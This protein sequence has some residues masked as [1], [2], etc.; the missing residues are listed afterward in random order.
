[1][2]P[3]LEQAL[4]VDVALSERQLARHYGLSLEV[5]RRAGLNIQTVNVAPTARMKVT[6][7]VNFVT[8]ETLEIPA[9]EFRHL[10]GI[11][12]MRHQLGAGLEDWTLVHH[13]D[14]TSPDAIWRRGLETWAVEFDA[15]SYSQKT[16][17]EKVRSFR[18]GFDGQCWAVASEARARFLGGVLLEKPMVVRGF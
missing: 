13:T 9:F 1:V 5:C 3:H 10:A 17:L 15:G 12:E 4:T 14:H 8:L 7:A 16:I 11:A 18:A 2:I 6:R